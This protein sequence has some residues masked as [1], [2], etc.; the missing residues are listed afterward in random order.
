MVN[1]NLDAPEV[2]RNPNRADSTI[3]YRAVMPTGAAGFISEVYLEATY[4]GGLRLP[5]C[6]A[7]PATPSVT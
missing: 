1:Y 6:D 7:I 2:Q 4:R 3:W 5:E